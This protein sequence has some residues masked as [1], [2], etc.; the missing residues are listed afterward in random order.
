MIIISGSINEINIYK[1]NCKKWIKSLFFYYTCHL[2]LQLPKLPSILFYLPKNFPPSSHD[3][4]QFIFLTFQNQM[5]SLSLSLSPLDNISSSTQILISSPSNIWLT[6]FVDHQHTDWK[7]ISSFRQKPSNI[8]SLLFNP[9]LLF[10]L[11]LSLSLSL[12]VNRTGTVG[13]KPGTGPNRN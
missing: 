13:S 10:S 11:S 7:P 6:H 9:D 3:A 1:R 8:S 4:F 12:S 5:F 2:W